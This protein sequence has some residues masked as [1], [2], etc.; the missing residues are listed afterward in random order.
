MLGRFDAVWRTPRKRERERERE[1][2]GEGEREWRALTNGSKSERSLAKVPATQETD[3]KSESRSVANTSLAVY[4]E[5][6]KAGELL[7]SRRK[8]L[9]KTSPIKNQPINK[10][11]LSDIFLL[12]ELLFTLFSAFVRSPHVQPS[13]LC[14]FPFQGEITPSTLVANTIQIRVGGALWDGGS[15][16]TCW[17]TD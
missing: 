9:I 14:R 4:H 11:K 8:K 7:P 12:D 16:E 6:V 3:K 17:L 10:L 5:Q 13:I 1:R 2:E 15:G